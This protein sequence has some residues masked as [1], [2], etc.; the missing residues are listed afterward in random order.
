MRSALDLQV[1]QGF[2]TRVRS[3]VA[4]VNFLFFDYC[5]MPQ[6]DQLEVRGA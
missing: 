1:S 3:F 5:S 2:L 6:T 4:N